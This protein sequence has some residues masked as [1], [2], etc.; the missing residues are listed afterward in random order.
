MVENEN[1]EGF[2]FDKDFTVNGLKKIAEKI[3]AKEGKNRQEWIDSIKEK[4]KEKGAVVRLVKKKSEA[5]EKKEIE[6]GHNKE[7][8]DLDDIKK[9]E[10]ELK[11]REKKEGDKD[12]EGYKIH[13]RKLLI[14]YDEVSKVRITLNSKLRAHLRKL[15]G[16]ASISETEKLKKE[17]DE[18][19]KSLIEIVKELN[20]AKDRARNHEKYQKRFKYLTVYKDPI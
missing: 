12:G 17:A 10:K 4:I 8:R 3:N 19:E 9:L 18:A 11:L 16:G 7:E 2:E 15:R 13:V 5:E 1:N 6:Q 20:G 14:L